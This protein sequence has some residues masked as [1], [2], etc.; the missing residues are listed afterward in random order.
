[1]KIFIVTLKIIGMSLLLFIISVFA[2]NLGILW[3][4][5]DLY[6]IE[7]V[8]HGVTY[9]AVAIL[10]IKILVNKGLKKLLSYYR[11]TSFRIYPLC[12]ILG[13]FLPLTVVVV[14]YIFVPGNLIMTNYKSSKD[15]VEML[16]EGILI[17]GIVAPIVE[18]IV[19]RGVL[20]KYIEEK[21]NIVFA[22][23]VTSILFS[24]VHLFNG[25]LV[26]MDRY[27]LIIAGT[28]AGIMYATA[29]YVYNSI[30]ASI[31]LHAFW[32][33]WGLFAISNS[34]IDYGIFQYVINN[35]NIFITGGDYGMDASLISIS[36]YIL[37]SAILILKKYK[38]NDLKEIFKR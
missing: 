3:H 31:L 2:Q 26:G 38:W 34:K 29:T 19:F 12:L 15:Y 30:W 35:N 11:I 25:E 22:V 20:L 27:L 6:T 5:F 23:I 33:L 28:L 32:N 36:G 1:M 10:L 24:V 14:Y 21:T 37:I 13:F 7:Y 8:L 16:I 9:L 4:V 18:E 17:T